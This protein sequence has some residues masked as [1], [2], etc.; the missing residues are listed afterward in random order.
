MSVYEKT[1]DKNIKAAE[2]WEKRIDD[3]VDE[4]L[5]VCENCKETSSKWKPFCNKCGAFNP[6][7]WHVCLKRRT[8]KN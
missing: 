6:F 7:K 3:C 1:A 5:W 2:S 4:C 8:C